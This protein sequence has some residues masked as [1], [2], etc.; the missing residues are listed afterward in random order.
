MPRGASALFP[1]AIAIDERIRV[2]CYGV[3]C[4]YYT[5]V[6]STVCVLKLYREHSVQII[7]S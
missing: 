1:V 2:D 6:K 7:M 3:C 5:N 4:V